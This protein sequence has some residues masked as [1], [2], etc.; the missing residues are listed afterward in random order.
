MTWNV[1]PCYKF[2]MTDHRCSHWDNSAADL[3]SR[4]PAATQQECR[5]L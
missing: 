5:L 3:S 1:D 2:L 4:Q